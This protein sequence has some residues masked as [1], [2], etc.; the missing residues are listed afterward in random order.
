MR[1]LV[2]AATASLTLAACV[3][4]EKVDTASAPTFGH[5]VSSNYAAQASTTPAS[6]QPPVGTGTQGAL[7][8]QRYNSGQTKPLMPSSTALTQTTSRAR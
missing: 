6:E 3:S 7:A 2:F 1:N 5:A 8:Q 4:S